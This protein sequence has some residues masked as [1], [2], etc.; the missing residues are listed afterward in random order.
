MSLKYN[1]PKPKRND[2]KAAKHK[3]GEGVPTSLASLKTNPQQ[4]IPWRA[5]DILI[6]TYVRS[7]QYYYVFVLTI[8][9]WHGTF[10]LVIILSDYTMC[11]TSSFLL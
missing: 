7:T 2:I 6:E 8:Y 4:R 10:L 9:K 1:L 5:G 3:N 11:F